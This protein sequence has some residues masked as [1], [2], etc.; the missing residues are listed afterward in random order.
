MNDY[1]LNN[2]AER[3]P[4]YVLL[5]LYSSEGNILDLRTLHLKTNNLDTYSL[6]LIYRY[7]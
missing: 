4:P 5:A 6:L 3:P 2:A 1:S 7:S